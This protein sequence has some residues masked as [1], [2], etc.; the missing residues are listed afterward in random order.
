LDTKLKGV[1]ALLDFTVDV[2]RLFD[3]TINDSII[4]KPDLEFKQETLKLIYNFKSSILNISDSDSIE[5]ILY[6]YYPDKEQEDSLEHSE[7]NKHDSQDGM[8]DSVLQEVK[9][10]AD[11]LEEEMQHQNGYRHGSDNGKIHEVVETVVRLEELEEEGTDENDF[12]ADESGKHES[13]D[14][15]HNHGH[16]KVITL[17]DKEHNE[18]VLTRPNDLTMF[19]EGEKVVVRRHLDEML[20]YHPRL[21]KSYRY[22]HCFHVFD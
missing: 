9:Y 18:Y 10:S 21:L 4:A 11:L 7:Y 2:L 3:R 13:E 8:V 6:G 17:I 15:P 19:Y 1:T 22:T 20:Q 12:L 16:A 14:G 5:N